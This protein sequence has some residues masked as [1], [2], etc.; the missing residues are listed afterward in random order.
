MPLP[1][2]SVCLIADRFT[3]EAVQA[4]VIQAAEAGIR[5]VQLRDHQAEDDVFAREARRIVERLREIDPNIVININAR[6]VVAE[7]LGLDFHTGRLGPAVGEARARLGDA[8]IGYS[9]HDAE[10]AVVARQEG[11]DYITFSPIFPT[12]SKP[13]AQPAGL[14]ALGHVVAVVRPLPVVALGG[15]DAKNA[16]SCIEAGARAVAVI[17]SVLRQLDIVEAVRNLLEAVGSAG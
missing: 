11:A 5:W 16:A 3:D 8:V 9:A 13:D 1:T 4:S 7:E 12:A 10:E 6:L 2:S 17:G 15:I 14:P